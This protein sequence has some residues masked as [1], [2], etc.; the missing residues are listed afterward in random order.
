MNYALPSTTLGR[1]N[2]RKLQRFVAY[3]T[4]KGLRAGTIKGYLNGIRQLHNLERGVDFVHLYPTPKLLVEGLATLE[5]QVGITQKRKCPFTWEMA[6]QVA[7]R[8]NLSNPLQRELVTAILCGVGFLLRASEFVRC[9][10][11]T[12]HLQR[13]DVVLAWKD[14][15]LLSVTITVKQ[16]K[17]DRTPV[18]LTLPHT[19][20]WFSVPMMLHRYCKVCHHD[21]KSAAPLF[22]TLTRKV[23]SQGI[24][25]WAMKLGVLD[26]G[27][28]FASHSLRRGGATTLLNKGVPE[29]TIQVFGRWK[30][31]IWKGLYARLSYESQLVLGQAFTTN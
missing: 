20:E 17:T 26:T 31:D 4:R 10:N 21:A 22:P 3:L 29:T 30:T 1:A 12:F 5:R 23:L 25:D 14:G 27:H 15:A 18:P 11:T 28:G 9:D 16:S 13:K 19:G 6:V 24:A 7:Q 2:N 8:S